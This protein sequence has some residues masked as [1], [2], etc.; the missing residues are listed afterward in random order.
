MHTQRDRKIIADDKIDHNHH[1]LPSSDLSFTNSEE[2][3]C[4]Y[5]YNLVQ[6]YPVNLVIDQFKSLFIDL[7]SNIEANLLTAIY[8]IINANQYI[9]F[10][11][12]LKRSCYI[13]L[14]N[15]HA[16]V[17]KHSL[18]YGSQLI[19]TLPLVPQ[20]E[21]N[22]SSS[23]KRINQWINTFLESKEYAELRLLYP[24]D[25]AKA[26]K[27]V[28]AEVKAEVKENTKLSDRY[29]CYF[30]ASQF[31]NEEKSEEERE[32]A[33]KTYQRL[34]EKFK[35]DLAMYTVR[36]QS[37][38]FGEQDHNNPTALGDK[39]LHLIQKVLAKRGAF[40]HANLANIFLKQT[41]GIMYVDFKRSLVK[42]LTNSLGQTKTALTVIRD[43]NQYLDSL[44][45]DHHQQVWNSNLLLRTANRLIELLTTQ[46][47]GE[48]SRLFAVL[49]TQ[50]QSLLLVILLLKIVLICK[51]SRSH[52]ESCIAYLIAYY[53]H[54]TETDCRWLVVFLE[55]L[56][57]ALTICLENVRFN[58]VNLQQKHPQNFKNIKSQDYWVFSQIT[59]QKTKDML[60][61]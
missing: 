1:D 42:Y 41:E 22:L 47:R 43:L 44:Y 21:D 32:A 9:L 12:T 34:Q 2:V 49:A 28:K 35:F 3:I 29:T 50:E 10:Q 58:V 33:R 11:S 8:S 20:Q 40:S 54:H 13:L 30:L 48:P 45:Q 6:N 36:S 24:P 46:K 61:R 27:Q 5:F 25:N 56:E 7:D 39:V 14:N 4:N 26:K 23:K 19:D 16:T 60:A 17:P 52:L 15:W 37:S 18:K 53:D 55:T 57:V 31:I 38:L 59:T 51:Q